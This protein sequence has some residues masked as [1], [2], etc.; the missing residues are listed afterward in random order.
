MAAKRYKALESSTPQE[1][2]VDAALYVM[3]Q[4]TSFDPAVHDRACRLVETT[5]HRNPAKNP[6][7]DLDFHDEAKQAT[8]ILIFQHP[9]LKRVDLASLTRILDAVEGT[10][11]RS[12]AEGTPQHLEFRAE[13]Y[14]AWAETQK[15]KLGADHGHKAA[16]K[17]PQNAL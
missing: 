12:G 1:L 4:G 2:D 14:S 17:P 13:A 3:A 5:L 6:V 7:T 10:A 8:S 9:E 16:A 15:Q 11:A